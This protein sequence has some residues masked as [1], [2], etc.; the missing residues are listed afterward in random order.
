M[1]KVMTGISRRAAIIV[2]ALTLAGA[3]VLSMT[4]TAFAVTISYGTT[5]YDDPPGYDSDN[6]DDN[7]SMG[8]AAITGAQY[9]TSTGILTVYVQPLAVGPGGYI[10]GIW[11]DFN[12]NGVVDPGEQGVL[13]AAGNGYEF[14]PPS[15]SPGV[16]DGVFNITMNSGGHPGGTAVSGDLLIG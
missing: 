6:P 16:F 8:D 9:D 5:L 1:A 15:F 12:G 7:I 3:M 4:T 14:E 13:N 2:L 10:S 11:L